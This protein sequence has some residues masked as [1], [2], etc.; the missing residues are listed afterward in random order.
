MRAPAHVLVVLLGSAFGACALVCFLVFALLPLPTQGSRGLSL[1]VFSIEPTVQC[2]GCLIWG[3]VWR[4]G[5]A[6][7]WFWVVSISSQIL[8][9]PTSIC[10]RQALTEIYIQHFEGEGK[11]CTVRVHN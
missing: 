5:G 6:R 11:F 2:D 4:G 10:D 8:E 1:I 9:H 7:G 3:L